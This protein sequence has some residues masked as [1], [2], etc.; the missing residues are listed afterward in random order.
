MKM[1]E[2][3][4]RGFAAAMRDHNPIHLDAAAARKAGLSGPIVHGMLILAR[5]EAAL[6]APASEFSVRFVQPLPVGAELSVE[7]RPLPGG[8]TR[9]IAR[10]GEGGILAVGEAK[11]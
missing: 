9:V 6:G 7:T 5:M 2:T 8:R 4:V 3:S 1:D 11:A 10:N